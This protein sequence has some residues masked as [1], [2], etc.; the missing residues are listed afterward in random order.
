MSEDGL[1]KELN[2]RETGAL[3]GLCRE[4]QQE[5][6]LPCLTVG[7]AHG[8]LEVLHKIPHTRSGVRARPGVQSGTTQPNPTLKPRFES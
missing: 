6:L 2:L 5:L 4:V 1:V 8:L 7:Q 3:K